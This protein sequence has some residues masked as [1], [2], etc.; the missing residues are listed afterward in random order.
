MERS[1]EEDARR[2]TGRSCG[3]PARN[4]HRGHPLE[5]LVWLANML[6]ERGKGLTAGTVIITGSIVTPKFLNPGDVASVAIEGIG[7]A[8]LEVI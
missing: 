1:S 5:P 8:S 7:E 2:W 3:P 4:R 6:A